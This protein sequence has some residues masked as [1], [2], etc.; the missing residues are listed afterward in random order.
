MSGEEVRK[1]KDDLKIFFF[2]E[3]GEWERGHLDL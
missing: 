3:D 2:F 1:G